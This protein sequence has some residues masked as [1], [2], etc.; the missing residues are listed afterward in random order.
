VAL[1][2]KLNSAINA[3]AVVGKFEEQKRIVEVLR[4]TKGPIS[5]PNGAAY[6]LGINLTTLLYRM[7][8]LGIDGHQIRRSLA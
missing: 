8:K 6:R 3:A 1:P 2:D 4:E 7:D 5:G